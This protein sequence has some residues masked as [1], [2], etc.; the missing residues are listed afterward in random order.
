MG[1]FNPVTYPT[2]EHPLI[3][4]EVKRLITYLHI[5]SLK[6]Q[7]ARE[8]MIQQS[9]LERRHNDG[10]ISLQQIYELLT[11]M[12]DENIINKYNRDETMVVLKIYFT[13]HFPA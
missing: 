5:P 6:D 11:K 13:E 7:E 12:K 3:E 1:F 10:K 2:I 8:K 9:I 4:E